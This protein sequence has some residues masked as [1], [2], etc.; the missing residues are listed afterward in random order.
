[1]QELSILKYCRIPEICI[2]PCVGVISID[3]QFFIE[4][5]MD[6]VL[7]NQV[8]ARLYDWLPDFWDFEWTWVVVVGFT[9]D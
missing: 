2:D 3:S 8:I 5:I 9:V 4:I 6:F 7:D 1:L